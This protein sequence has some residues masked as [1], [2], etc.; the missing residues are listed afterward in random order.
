MLLACCKL[1]D[2]NSSGEYYGY[3]VS[4]AGVNMVGKS[5]AIDLRPKGIV[6]G[7]LHP[8]KRGGA[9]GREGLG[10]CLLST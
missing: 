9:F 3:R 7:L 6:V 5:L 4:K 10:S 1:A 8:G 2:D